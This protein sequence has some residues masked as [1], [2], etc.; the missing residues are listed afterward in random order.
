MSRIEEFQNLLARPND[1]V[2][3]KAPRVDLTKKNKER[4]SY[5]VYSSPGKGVSGESSN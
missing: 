4:P 2:K 3:K 5:A 1:L